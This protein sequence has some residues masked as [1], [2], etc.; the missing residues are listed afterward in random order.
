MLTGILGGTLSKKV[1]HRLFTNMVGG[2]A[3]TGASTV[4]YLIGI[5]KAS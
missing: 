2:H 4:N 1:M 3:L 5:G